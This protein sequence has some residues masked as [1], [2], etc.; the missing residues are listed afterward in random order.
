MLGSQYASKIDPFKIS[1]KCCGAINALKSQFYGAAHWDREVKVHMDFL[2]N[3]KCNSQSAITLHMFLAKNIDSFH[4]LQQCGDHV[5]V[6]IPSERT[7]VG[8]LLENIECNDK[9]ALTALSYVRLD[10]NV[11]GMR[12]EFE[13]E[14][15]FLL[16]TD[17]AKNKNKR[18]HAQISYVS[19]PRTA[20]KGREKGK[21]G[22]EGLVQTQHLEDWC[23]SHILKIWR[24]FC[25]NSG[26]ARW[27]PVP[28]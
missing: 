24:I 12:N 17:P 7:R 4:S 10:N 11:N 20:I 9:D 3:G 6:D 5:T 23:W 2:L 22:K 16:P 14:V 13:R 1:N 19:T 27:A 15:A 8:H 25:I 28:S 18:R 21:L 26:V